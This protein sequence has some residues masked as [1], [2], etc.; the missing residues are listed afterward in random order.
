MKAK[1]VGDP[2]QPEGTE[3]IPENI[4]VRGIDFPKGKWVD[5]PDDLAAK[6]VGHSHFETKGEEPEVAAEAEAKA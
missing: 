3:A 1:F 5:V 6:F 2:S 4:T